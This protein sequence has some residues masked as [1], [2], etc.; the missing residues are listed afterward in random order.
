MNMR[1]VWIVTT[2]FASLA[3]VILAVEPLASTPLPR[4][5]LEISPDKGNPRNSEGDFAI[6]KD[7]SL[8]YV[9]THFNG[10]SSGDSAPAH[11][12]SRISHDGGKTWSQ[13]DHLELTCD[14]KVN[15]MSVSLLR[16]RNGKLAMF[17]LRKDGELDGH[18]VMRTSSDEGKTWGE[19]VVCIPPEHRGYY[20]LNNSRA[21]LT[22]KGR[23]VLPLAKHNGKEGYDID[24]RLTAALSDDDGKTWHMSKACFQTFSPYD[25][26]RVSTQEPGVIEL[27]DGRLMMW[28]RTLEGV[29]YVTFSSDAGDTWTRAVPWNLL[30]PNSAASVIRLSTGDLCAVWNDHGSNFEVKIRDWQEKA[31]K[32][33]GYGSRTPLT[34]ALSKDEGHTW[35]KVRNLETEPSPHMS[36]VAMKEIDGH[37]ML[38]YWSAEPQGYGVR[39]TRVP[40][41]YLYGPERPDDQTG[42]LP[43]IFARA[44]V[45]I[46][47]SDARDRTYSPDDPVMTNL[48]NC[49]PAPRWCSERNRICAEFGNASPN[50]KWKE[51]SFSFLPRHDG[52][53]TVSLMGNHGEKTVYD[54][55]RVTGA[56][57]LNPGFEDEVKSWRGPGVGVGTEKTSDVAKPYG[58]V[59]KVG[60]NTPAEGKKMAVCS[61]ALIMSQDIELKKGVPVTIR[62]KAM[63][64]RK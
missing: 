16:L 44:V 10:N 12:A 7:G 48:V 24:G 59:G 15:V 32:H 21:I 46:D 41:A 20:V 13:Q 3:P 40:L 33:G 39:I 47:V 61:H 25:D 36:Y 6:L 57:L 37:V 58:I 51:Y 60:Q 29:Q 8:L 45:R 64:W 63:A 56:K 30:S 11:L 43:R 42:V 26:S 5:V 31:Y 17:Y 4:R 22:K 23:I 14:G 19:P 18:P 49:A 54:D 50:G 38:A 62:F 9:Y 55:F 28:T 53:F 34:I 1:R 2:A 27:K 35:I 52:P